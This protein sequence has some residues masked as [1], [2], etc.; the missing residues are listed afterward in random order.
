[1]DQLSHCYAFWLFFGWKM[2]ELAHWIDQSLILRSL[3]WFIETITNESWIVWIRSIVVCICICCYKMGGLDERQP[4]PFLI[5]LNLIW[6]NY[7]SYS[8][9]KI[10]S[11][12][13]SRKKVFFQP[14]SHFIILSVDNSHVISNASLW[15]KCPVYDVVSFYF[16]L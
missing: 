12:R 13:F 8:Q 15:V 3:K 5:N 14:R 7:T 6:Q 11:Q 2:Y 4:R 9:G 16:L 1:M 10:N